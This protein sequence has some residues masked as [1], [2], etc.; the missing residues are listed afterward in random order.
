[1]NKS[2]VV[3]RLLPLVRSRIIPAYQAVGELGFAFVQGS[4]V[5]GYTDRADLDLVLVWRTDP[6]RADARPVETVNDGARPYETYDD[7]GFVLDR[8]WMDGQEFGVKHETEAE[9]DR[10]ITAV[11]GGAGWKGPAY[12]RPLAAVAGFFYGIVVHDPSGRAVSIRDDLDTFPEELVERSR[13]AVAMQ[14]P[15]YLE[16]LRGCAE[17]GD[18]LLFHELLAE[19]VKILLVGWFSSHHVYMPHEKWLARAIDLHGLDYRGAELERSVWTQGPG[20]YERIAAFE[21]L[22]RFVRKE[23]GLGAALH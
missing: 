9:I 14:M 19:A 13:D 18:G 15:G 17:R 7:P 12:P 8:F 4:L 11:R 2:A 5:S 20:L 16:L 6:P 23:C 1:M 10:W 3:T 22:I 21:A